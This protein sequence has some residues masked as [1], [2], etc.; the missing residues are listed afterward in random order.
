MKS[1][2]L[3]ALL[4][5]QLVVSGNSRKVFP[6]SGACSAPNVQYQW[7]AYN[8]AIQCGAGSCADGDHIT[9]IPALRGSNTLTA[10]GDGTLVYTAGAVNGL[11]AWTNT[12]NGRHNFLL[13]AS[14]I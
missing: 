2:I 5:L 8:P 7:A 4:A 9:S 13:A 3:G 11:P 14:P 12:Y 10:M 6:P 1:L